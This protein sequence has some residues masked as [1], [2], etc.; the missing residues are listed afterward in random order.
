M[1][2][3]IPGTVLKLKEGMQKNVF[4]EIEPIFAVT[5]GLTLAQVRELTG[6]ESSTIQNWV[7]RGWV[8]RP[9]EKRYLKQQLIRIILI[10]SLRDAMQLEKIP[11]IMEY[12]NG[13]VDDESDDIIS[14]TELFN[15]FCLTVYK[16]INEKTID[17]NIIKSIINEQFNDYC[18]PNKDSKERLTNGLLIMTLAYLSAQLKVK[19]EEE[20]EKVFSKQ[21]EK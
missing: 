6:L 5:K 7:K 11:M 3:Y 15:A 8:A 17:T 18:G 12:I 1:M 13:V 21:N 9:I 16:C 19:T 4:Q 10:N 20:F 2:K 14:D